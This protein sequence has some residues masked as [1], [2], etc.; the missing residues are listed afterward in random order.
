[1]KFLQHAAIRYCSPLLLALALA[2]PPAVQA[3]SQ[4]HKT[5][6]KKPA[7]AK[8]KAAKAK[9]KARKVA[10]AKAAP[11]I[12]YAG[13]Q[14]N[15]GEWMAVSDFADEMVIKHG[16]ERAALDA[17]IAQIR[18]VDSAVQL[19]KP[20]PPGKP[21]NWQA[22]HKL[23]IE[24]V[25]VDGGVKFWDENA[26]TLARAE[27]QF[28]VPAE[29][30]VGIIGVE[31]VYGRNTGRFRVLDTLATLAFAYPET[32]NRVARMAFFR[33]ELENTL[34]LA[35]KTGID[36]LSLLGSFAGAVGM[37]QFMPGSIMSY[38]IDFDGSGAVDLRNSAADAIG[39][40]ANFLV[41]HGWRREDTGPQV[42]AAE[43]SPSRAWEPFIG[44]GLVAKFRQ[45]DLM[46][47]GVVSNSALPADALFGLVDLQNGAEP[48]EYWLA[49]NNFFAITQYNRSY[50]Y[51]MSVIELGRAVRLSRPIHPLL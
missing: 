28:G 12:D 21:K 14:I 30:I 31:T 48:T 47:A 18:F 43:V 51:A 22:V 35:R 16:F 1:M 23:F 34:L 17:L 4:A 13:E 25:R 5:S 41:R 37:P 32:P 46:A 20:A 19:I 42:Y 7:G 39:S 33:S 6:Q 38:G 2:A 40:V 26:D 11:K 24:P 27:A 29:I 8:A 10:P 15:F 50:F 49:T 9:A 44:Q 36:P 3:A 45:E